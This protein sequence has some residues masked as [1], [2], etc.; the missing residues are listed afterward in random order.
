[1]LSG[2][3]FMFSSSVSEDPVEHDSGMVFVTVVS[4]TCSWLREDVEREEEERKRLNE[5][6]ERGKRVVEGERRKG[7]RSKDVW[8]VC[9]ACSFIECECGL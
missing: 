3:D 6:A 5:D 8:I 7:L 4:M 2:F 9:L 1:M